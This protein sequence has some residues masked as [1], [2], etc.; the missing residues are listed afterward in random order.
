MFQGGSYGMYLLWMLQMLFTDHEMYDPGET[1]GNSHG[2]KNSYS[3]NDTDHWIK[4]P[5]PVPVDFFFKVHPKTLEHHSL[6][7]NVNKLTDYF[8][9]SILL[10]PSKNTYLLHSNNFTYKIWKD[11]WSGP[12]AY[13]DRNNLYENFPVSRETKLENVP[14]CIV[15][16]WL[17]YNFF[18]SMNAQLEWFLPDRLKS[19][20]C[21]IIFID[22][23]LYNPNNTINR[24]REFVNI[25]FVKPFDTIISHHQ[26]NLS[27]QQYI[28]QDSIANTIVESVVNN[29]IEYNWESKK[30]TIITEAWVQRE[31]C[32]K[33][34]NLK[35][36]EL[37]IFPTSTRC[38]IELLE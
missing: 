14:I 11:L 22:D 27:R 17:S 3:I 8:G 25:D 10:Y 7:T 31:L 5:H 32:N 28:Y 4:S 37:N 20:K 38:L 1:N 24:I 2:L 21:L 26:T 34:Y 16:E 35:C 33:G 19:D 23:L 13:M 18:N 15:R 6:H 12:L 9:K 36:N 29:D 30:L